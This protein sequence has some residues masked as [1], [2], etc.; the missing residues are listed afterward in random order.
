MLAKQT[1]HT[2]ITIV[3]RN[4]L[5]ILYIEKIKSE[6]AEKSIFCLQDNWTFKKIF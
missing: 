5:K 6:V 1:T 3:L 2:H 4:S